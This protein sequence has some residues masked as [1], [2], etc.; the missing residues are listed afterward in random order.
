MISYLE[1]EKQAVLQGF[2]EL[3]DLEKLTIEIK[4]FR[5][6]RSLDANAYCW[7]LISEIAERLSVP[8]EEVYRNAIREI[9]GNMEV[10]C[11]RNDAVLRLRQGW[12]R[13]GIGWLTDT[14]PSKIEGCT[15]V[16]L[17]YGSS[18]Y[19][20]RQMSRLIDNIVQ[21]CKELGIQTDTPNEIAKMKAMWGEY[22]GEHNTERQDKVLYMRSESVWRPS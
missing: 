8:K 22:H 15:N 12:E 21:D 10:V 3:K 13:N 6:R 18:S 1:S 7:K 20:T 4:P 16:M 14:F 2:D 17:Y 5:E 9:G 19:D 11:V